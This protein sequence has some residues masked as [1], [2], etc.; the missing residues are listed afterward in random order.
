MGQQ[1]FVKGNIERNGTAKFRQRKYRKE[2]DSKVSSK[3]IKKGLG[4]QS[5]VK[6]NQERN[7]TAKFTEC[8]RIS[9]QRSTA[10]KAFS[11]L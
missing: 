1:S 8:Y 6:G 11:E 4:Q 7:G 5:F 3:E 2:W 9:Q 10:T